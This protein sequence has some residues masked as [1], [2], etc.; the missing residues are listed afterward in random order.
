MH[1]GGWPMNVGKV[2]FVC[3]IVFLLVSVV[4]CDDAMAQKKPV[5]LRLVTAT[6]AK[7]PPVSEMLDNMAERFNE[8]AKGEYKMEIHRGGAL[9][10]LPEFFDAVKFGTVEMAMSAWGIFANLDPRFGAMEIPF[11]TNSFDADAYAAPRYLPLYDQILQERF[12]AKALSLF[13]TG[14]FD[15]FSTR[16]IKR[17]EDFKGVMIGAV[18]PTA[19]QLVK[20]L[21]GA[22]VT[23][24]WVDIYESLQ[25]K[26]IDAAIIQPGAA[27]TTNVVDVCKYLVLSDVNASFTG[28]TINLDVWKKMPPTIQRI[29]LE[30]A[31]AGADYTHKTKA[32]MLDDEVKTVRQKGLDVYVLPNAERSRWIKASEE[33]TKS[34]LSKLG[35]FGTKMK[36]I[37]DEANKKF[38]FK[39]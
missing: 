9:A 31:K 5:V 26:V 4:V 32:K 19:A 24:M 23:I 28:I 15:V 11:M 36:Q 7:A 21:G 29:L 13:A 20:D 1:A 39:E 16:P 33:T 6:P 3:T 18:N 2:F 38:P 27:L 34:R 25:K 17:I 22:P 12:N 35:D 30:E 10:K 37:A 8:R 14:G